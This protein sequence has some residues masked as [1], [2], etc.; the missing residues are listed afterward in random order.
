MSPTSEIFH[1]WISGVIGRSHLGLDVAGSVDPCVSEIV[2]VFGF[3]VVVW[4]REEYLTFLGFP[5]LAV[6]PD[7]WW[8]L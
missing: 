7:P 4:G 3:C 8:V 5:V 1:P 2:R 6:V